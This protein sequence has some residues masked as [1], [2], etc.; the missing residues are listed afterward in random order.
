MYLRPHSFRL[1]S[2]S[3]GPFPYQVIE[4]ET[5]VQRVSHIFHILTQ[6]FHPL[7]NTIRLLCLLLF[8]VWG[9]HMTFLDFSSTVEYSI[10]VML[11]VKDVI[12]SVTN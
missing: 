1:M 2:F 3:Q 6:P 10:P 12:L 4:R 11:L 8:T 9:I 7:A 5:K